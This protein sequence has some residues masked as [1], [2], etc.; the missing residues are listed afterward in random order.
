VR[1]EFAPY[2]DKPDLRIEI[3]IREVH[4]YIA[5]ELAEVSVMP[6]VPSRSQRKRRSEEERR[7]IQ[8][9]NQRRI[10][11]LTPMAERL[12]RMLAGEPPVPATWDEVIPDPG[13]HMLAHVLEYGY[14]VVLCPSCQDAYAA[15]ELLFYD[16]SDGDIVGRLVT[17]PRDHAILQTTDRIGVICEPSPPYARRLRERIVTKGPSVAVLYNDDVSR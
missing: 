3:E 12:G 1:V 15:V 4:S 16:W 14:G 8:E 10:D 6:P 17:C 2:A 13:R 11:R 5:S 7:Q 9:S